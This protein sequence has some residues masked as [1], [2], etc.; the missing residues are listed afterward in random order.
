MENTELKFILGALKFASEK[1]ILLKRKDVEGTPYIHH[2]IRVTE[3]IC[4]VGKIVDVT[5]LSAALL[6]DVIEDTDATEGDIIERFGAEVAGIVKEVTDDK[7][8]DKEK[9]K[10]LQILHAP[11]LSHNAKLIKLADK[12]CNVKDIGSHPPAKWDFERKLE[13]LEW[14][15]NVVAGLRGVNQ[16]LEDLFNQSLADARL[17]LTG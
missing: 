6:H 2:P 14:S 4:R 9:R 10:E 13:Y 11:H 1:H 12:I 3:L 17:K 7:S 8:L 15:K 16:P 5:V